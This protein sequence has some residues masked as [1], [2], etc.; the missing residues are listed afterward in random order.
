MAAGAPALRCATMSAMQRRP[1][2]VRHVLL[3]TDLERPSR[4]ATDEAIRLAAEHG[5]EQRLLS[6]ARQVADLP[7][8]RRA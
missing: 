1:L 5:A 6:D 3:A 8:G 7:P 2:P 4:R